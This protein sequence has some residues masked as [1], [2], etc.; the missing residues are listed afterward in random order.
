MFSNSNSLTTS[1]RNEAI[2]YLKQ[3]NTEYKNGRFKEAVK[4]YTKAIEIDSNFKEA[5]NNRNK[6]RNNIIH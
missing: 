4:Y 5:Y 2:G 3:G 1:E 6:A